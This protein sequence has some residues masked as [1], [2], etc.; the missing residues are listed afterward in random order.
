[1]LLGIL[2]GLFYWYLNLFLSDLF[3]ER[4]ENKLTI[5]MLNSI[6]EIL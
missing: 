1:M 6:K 2:F 4:V 5:E 3:N